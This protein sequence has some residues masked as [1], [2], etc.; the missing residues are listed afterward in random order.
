MKKAVLFFIL[1]VFSAVTSAQVFY[2][3]PLVSVGRID[4]VGARLVHQLAYEI[5][6]GKN[7][8]KFLVYGEV[9]TGSLELKQRFVV[10][11]H[12][13]KR[14]SVYYQWDI[15]EP[16]CLWN[17]EFLRISV[18]PEG[19]TDHEHL[20]SFKD[21]HLNGT[22]DEYAKGRYIYLSEY[23]DECSDSKYQKKFIEIVKDAL[24]FFNR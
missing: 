8:G 9:S 3:D 21:Y 18:R 10:F 17:Y 23:E 16:I 7:Q 15:S 5:T 2:L 12:N 13:G 22:W 14:F 19:T 6:S 4:T 1:F 24:A 20:I 11:S